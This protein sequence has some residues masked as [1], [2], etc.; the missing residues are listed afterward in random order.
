MNICEGKEEKPGHK[1]KLGDITEFPSYILYILT[2]LT[3][4][5]PYNRGCMPAALG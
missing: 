1:E 5:F 2:L 4:Y 3:C